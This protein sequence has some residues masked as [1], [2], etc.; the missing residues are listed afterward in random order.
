M[1]KTVPWIFYKANYHLSTYGL[2]S[3][4][5]ANVVRGCVCRCQYVSAI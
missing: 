1:H 5:N 2:M 3:I 4:S